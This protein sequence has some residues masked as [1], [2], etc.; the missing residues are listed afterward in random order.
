MIENFINGFI[1]EIKRPN[2]F[3][4]SLILANKFN[5]DVLIKDELDESMPDIIVLIGDE[6]YDMFGK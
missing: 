2:V 5:G 1:S 4:F 3:L 6:F